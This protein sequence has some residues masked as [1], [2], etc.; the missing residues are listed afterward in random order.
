MIIVIED[1]E[2][3]SV[4]DSLFYISKLALQLML[5]YIGNVIE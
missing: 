4:L 2:N 1:A 5:R 3:M